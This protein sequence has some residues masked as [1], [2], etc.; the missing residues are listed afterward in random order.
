MILGRHTNLKYKN[1]SRNFWCRGYNA[2]T[3]GENKKV[4]VEYIKNQLEDDYA[5]DQIGKRST[6]TRLRVVRNSRQK[7]QPH[8]SD[9]L[10]L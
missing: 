10:R 7:R 4:I 8:V 1:G 6:W 2:D 3:V 9:C 5:S